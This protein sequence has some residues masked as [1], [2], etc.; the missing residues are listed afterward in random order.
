MLSVFHLLGFVGEFLFFD[1]VRASF[2][3][4][5][6]PIGNVEF[7]AARHIGASAIRLVTGSTGTAEQIAE[8]YRYA[9]CYLVAVLL[10]ALASTVVWS[11]MDR[12]RAEYETLNRWLRVYARYALA[13]V[14]IVYALVKVVPTQF[15]FLTPGELLRPVGQLNRF[16]VLW[17]FMAVSTGY[18]IFTGLIELLGC[19]LLFFRRT[20]LL[21]GLLLAAALANVLAM[22][23]AY[24]VF[25]AAMVAGLLIALATIVIAP[26]AA[27]LFNVFLLGQSD[28]MPAEP[29][30]AVAR[31]RYAPVAK[32][33]V[34]VGL[35]SVRV[36]DGMEQRR[37]Y[38][39]RGQ[40]VYGM[41][42]V[43]RFIRGGVPITSTADDAKTWKRIASDGRYGGGPR[44]GLDLT[45]QFAN[46][47][48]RQYRLADDRANR[49]WTLREASKEI[50]TLRYAVG[51]NGS[52]S[53][54]GLIGGEAVQ[55]NLRPVD[56][57]TL[58]LLRRR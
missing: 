26:Y 40:A 20:T 23:I 3:R 1:A 4:G 5:V 30:T 34:L 33:L 31:W 58:P 44:G 9:S 39:G 46:G 24:T 45:V 49:L 12:R 47:D 28:R 8:R 22:D 6:A 27:P 25:G 29:T 51:P 38:F 17:N 2:E 43:D 57:H 35:I 54:D 32:V 13:L 50:A 19:V 14:M 16:W 42:E 48:V 41:F 18:T 37:T 21:G 36:S 15:G 7:R 55:V 56:M 52:V 11:I 53:L 10:V